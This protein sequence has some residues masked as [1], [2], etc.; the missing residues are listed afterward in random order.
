MTQI[1]SSDKIR[2][3]CVIAHVDHGK[4]TLIDSLLKQSGTFQ[5]HQ[6]I[7]ERVMDSLDLEK[8]RGI[9]ITSKN[10][11]IYYSDYKINIIDTPG[12][13][14]FG[15]EVQRILSM[16][17]GACLLVDASEGPLPQT[18][19]VLEN[20]LKYNLK[21]IVVINKVDRKDARADEVLNEIFDLFIELGATEEQCDF[22]YIYA[23]ARDG[24]ASKDF[25][26]CFETDNLTE[27]FDLITQEVPA[28]KI[29][30]NGHDI[31]Q[32][33]NLNYSDYLG[34]L[35]IGR[36][37]SG[38]LKR[39][40]AVAHVSTQNENKSAKKAKIQELLSYQ[41]L[42]TEK[43]NEVIAGDICL[44]SGIDDVFIGDSVIAIEP[45]AQITPELIELA[46]KTLMIDKPTMEIE[47]LVNN[48]PLA[49]KEGKLVT[50]RKIKDRLTKEAYVNVAIEFKE[51]DEADRFI[52]GARGE[53]QISIL[54]ETMRREGFEF[55]LGQPKIINKEINGVLHEPIEKITLDIP[56]ESQGTITK[57]F[58]E[59][60]GM[61][62]NIETKGNN[63]VRLVIHCPSRACIGL[64]SIFLTETRGEGLFN[65]EFLEYQEHKGKINQRKNGA[66]VCDRSGVSNSYALD[67]LQ[68]RGKLFIGTGI[69]VYEGMVIGEN[70]KA[71]NLDVNPCKAKQLTNFRTSNKDAA[72]KLETPKQL[73]I[74]NCLEW[75]NEDEIMEI[76]PLSLRLRKKQLQK[77]L[78]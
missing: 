74:E 36:L 45:G 59:R 18:R 73:T 76:T 56:E 11:A 13:S 34:R 49:G 2:N 63:R 14:D 53:L 42:K 28:P 27:L 44:I 33:V 69:P 65:R 6:E 22:S 12:H 62:Q 41:G 10:A 25:K 5:S 38:K 78:R 71:T 8:E 32:I 17:D 29:S 4:T 66:L 50:S 72:I 35:G 43:V 7:E 54:A 1:I 37:L 75:L 70:A 58:Q 60:K 31:L 55:A 51:T 9:T 67:S 64:R 20:A 16:V 15:G 48:S 68:A 19:Y 23:I 46:P 61:L 30:S 24:K 21:I 47:C 40:N 77:N 26:K 52:I 39:G 3:L 57:L